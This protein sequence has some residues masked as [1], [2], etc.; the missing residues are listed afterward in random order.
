MVHDEFED[1]DMIKLLL[2]Y[3]GDT[4][5]HTK[6]VNISTQHNINPLLK[7]IYVHKH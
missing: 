6:L 4:K 7:N 2:E 3:N 1:T 5:I